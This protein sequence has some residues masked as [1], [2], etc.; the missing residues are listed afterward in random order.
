[1]DVP[2]TLVVTNDYPPRVGGIQRTLEALVRQLP[3]NR[4]SV[5]CPDWNGADVFDEAAAYRVLRQPEG[6]LWPGP[7][8]GQ[9]IEAA[10]RDVEAE[11]VLFGATY[12]LAM[13][14]PRLWAAGIP[15]LAAA[16]GFEYWLSVMPGTHS[17]MRYATSK[18]ARVPV[19][20]SE[21]IAR[22]VRTA[23]PRRVPVSVLYPGADTEAFRPGLETGDLR[24]RHGLGDR[25][26]VVC[27]SRLVARKGQDVLIES[28][29]SIRARVPGATLLV[30]GTGPYEP[31]LRSMAA[32]APA[33]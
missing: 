10:A 16:H 33:G 5:M 18:A 30:V 24:D 4:V 17:M 27:V 1:M 6:F 8:V 22:T 32:A 31:R 7:R 12:P 21:F 28:M 13:A 3:A 9:R 19:M 23:V 25:P 14:G 15:Y 29:A 26:V 2:R 20:C 11:V